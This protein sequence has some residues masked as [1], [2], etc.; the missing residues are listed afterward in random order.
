MAVQIRAVDLDAEQEH[1]LRVLER[2]FSSFP[3]ARRFKWIY[4]DN[5]LGPAWSWLLWDSD[6]GQP[7]GVA[8]VFRRA[9]WVGDKVELCGQV[10]DF[11]IDQTHRSLGPALMLQRATFTPVDDGD[12]ALCYDCPPNARGM[13][14]FRRLRMVSNAT[15]TR[16]ARLL[17]TDRHVAKRLG[18]GR[19]A[20]AAARLAN[21]LLHLVGR[22]SSRTVG[23]DIAVHT[24]RFDEE[25]SLL[26]RRV[27]GDDVIRGRRAAEDLNWR[28]RD[29]PLQDYVVL[30]ARR[31][32][33]LCGF[34]VVTHSAHE[35]LVVDLFGVLSSEESADL[36]D[37]AA[38]VAWEARADALYVL[39]SGDHPLT[40]PL[41]H[42]GF[43]PRE[44][45]PYVVGHAQEGSS[46]T[47]REGGI[48]WRFTYSDVMA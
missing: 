30:T 44:N 19:V 1:L 29:D 21:T 32:G 6:P 5:P 27:G 48:T 42:A 16:Y 7:V 38:R 3:H 25:F 31:R 12:L 18:E 14:T 45:G 23:L 11:A 26:D 28:Y 20:A 13:S 43:W 8:S 24:A 40:G 4:R 46:G 9:L 10:G 2:N 39:I 36:L 47:L 34:A 17:R 22:R 41:R 33:E 35:A 15:M 37:A